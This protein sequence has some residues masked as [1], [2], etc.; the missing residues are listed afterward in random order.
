MNYTIGRTWSWPVMSA[1]A[2][3]V[4]FHISL[5]GWIL[6]RRQNSQKLDCFLIFKILMRSELVLVRDH[7]FLPGV[8]TC[9]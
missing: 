7:I 2:C 9:E 1:P 4:P 8:I 6:W 5:P 3:L